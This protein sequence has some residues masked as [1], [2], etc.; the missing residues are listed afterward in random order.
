[1]A[2]FFH[3]VPTWWVA[4][5]D[6][7]N[8]IYFL[9]AV[10]FSLFADRV[11]RLL[12]LPVLYSAKG[13]RFMMERDTKRR[14]EIMHAV[15]DSA[16]K[17]VLYMACY[18]LDSFIWIFWQSISLWFVLNFLIFRHDPHPTP[19]SPLVLG[20]TMAQAVK[21]KYLLEGLFNPEQTIKRLE[22]MLSKRGAK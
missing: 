18:C 8:F 11:R 4:H 6:W 10:L 17:L 2:N 3:A 7:V 1:M 13:M 16:F 12:S 5:P 9:L 21:L 15:G 20:L 22:E 14:L 19:L